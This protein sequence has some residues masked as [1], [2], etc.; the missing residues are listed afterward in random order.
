[1]R[2]D[3]NLQQAVAE[4]QDAGKKYINVASRLLAPDR[5]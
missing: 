4:A 3:G 5:D 1:V 2:V